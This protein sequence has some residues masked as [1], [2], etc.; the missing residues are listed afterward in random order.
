M[1]HTIYYVYVGQCLVRRIY[2]RHKYIDRYLQFPRVPYKGPS[3]CGRLDIQ[4]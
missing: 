3:G 1:A 4:G 2:T